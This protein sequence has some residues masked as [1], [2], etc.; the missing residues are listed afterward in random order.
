MPRLLKLFQSGWPVDSPHKVYTGLDEAG[1]ASGLRHNQSLQYDVLRQGYLLI[2]GVSRQQGVSLEQAAEIVQIWRGN[3]AAVITA[4]GVIMAPF[5]T[6]DGVM[7]VMTADGVMPAQ[8][9]GVVLN[10]LLPLVPHRKDGWTI[11]Q[12]CQYARNMECVTTQK[13]G[14]KAAA[15]REGGTA[16][17]KQRTK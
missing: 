14:V 17:K 2:K 4:D 1:F 12:L 13:N 15:G 6:A 5:M 16:A 10:S 8:A 3:T 7:A 11:N 9:A